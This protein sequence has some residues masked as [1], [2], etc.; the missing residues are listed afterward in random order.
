[1]TSHVRLLRELARDCGVQLSYRDGLKQRRTA[2]PEA[3]EAVLSALGAPAGSATEAAD[4]LRARREERLLRVAEPVTVARGDDDVRVIVRTDASYDGD[5]TARIAFEDGRETVL[6]APAGSLPAVAKEDAGDRAFIDREFTV[7]HERAWGYHRAHVQADRSGD[8]LLIVA[9]EGMHDGPRAAGVFAPVYA[10]RSDRDL[11][12][13]DLGSFRE[14]IDWVASRRGSL[15]ATLPLLSSFL[16]EPFDPSPY[17]PVSR[18]HWNELYLDVEAV[19]E[20]AASERAQAIVRDNARAIEQLRA[21]ED[22]DYRGVYA[23]KREILEACLASLGDERRAE[24]DAFASDSLREYARFRAHAERT[25]A[26]WPYWGEG[27]PGDGGDAERFHVYAQWLMNGRLDQMGRA[28]E[29]AGVHVYFDL[30]LGVHPDGYDTWRFRDVFAFGVSGGAPPDSFFT[31]GQNWRFPPLHPE[32]LRESGYA[33]PIASLRALLRHARI[34]RVDHIMGLHR[35]FWVPQGMEATDGVYVRSNPDE[36]YAV[37]AVESHRAGA[38]IVGEDLGTVPREVRAAM[39]RNNVL[40]SYVL[41]EEIP[42]APARAPRPVP[43]RSLAGLNTHDMPTFAAF[44]TGADIDDN[45]ALG[46]GSDEQAESD[47]AARRAKTKRLEDALRARGVVDRGLIDAG[48]ALDGSLALLARGSARMRVA[49]IEDFWLETRR[50]NLPGTT[51]DEQPNWRHKMRKSLREIRD[52]ATVAARMD[53]LT[54]PRRGV[55]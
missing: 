45:A 53:T 18:L 1:M 34:L 38:A 41:Q 54:A 51:A 20:F 43:T 30:P 24:M 29:Q 36:W 50:Q 5:V 26:P 49:S 13:G 14:L 12:C 23:I 17:A 10:L 39:A 48:A 47:R 16:G 7:P 22:V 2:S 28:A 42:D 46:L 33:Y 35:L 6:R 55:T 9:P 3:L 32:R 25:A 40:R 37:L 4:T 31:R 21:T 27:A 52:D 11:G 19:P 8:T 15:V 44:W